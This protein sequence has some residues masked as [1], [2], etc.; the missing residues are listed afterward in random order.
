MEQQSNGHVFLDSLGRHPSLLLGAALAL[1]KLGDH[2][3]VCRFSFG[4]FS[5]CWPTET[6]IFDL[7]NSQSKPI[8][9][10]GNQSVSVGFFGFLI[11]YFLR[12]Q[13]KKKKINKPR[14]Y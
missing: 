5:K 9:V 11:I 6:E 2:L 14:K 4:W 1:G 12:K 13:T 10:I 8:K 3:G 7:W